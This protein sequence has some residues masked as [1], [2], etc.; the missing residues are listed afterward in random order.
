MA[1]ESKTLC[2]V[3]DADGTLH[4]AENWDIL[5]VKD[6]GTIDSVFE[7]I[8][9]QDAVK[10]LKYEEAFHYTADELRVIADRRHE[11]TLDD[12]ALEQRTVNQHA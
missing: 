6:P 2:Y 12:I 11:E 4:L 9:V 7:S 8:G 10:A 5:W 1:D 3:R